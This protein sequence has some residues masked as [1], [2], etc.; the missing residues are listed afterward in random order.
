MEELVITKVLVELKD[1]THILTQQE[2][3]IHL[4]IP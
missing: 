1:T 4:N 3:F 2:F